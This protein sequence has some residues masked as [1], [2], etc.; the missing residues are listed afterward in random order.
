MA[1]ATLCG[2]LG[3]SFV[4]TQK[5]FPSLLLNV[6]RT[7]MALHSSAFLHNQATGK[8]SVN[9]AG[10][11]VFYDQRGSGSHPILC[12]PGALGTADGDF[13]PQLEYF[14]KEGGPYTIVGYDPMGYGASRP[15]ERNFSMKSE[16]FFER[17]ASDGHSL[18]Q[19]LSFPKFSLLG[20][21]DGGIAA[22]ILAARFPQAV[23]KL[24][25]WGANSY[26]TDKDI[27]LFENTRNVTSWSD[28]MRKPMEVMYGKTN[29]QNLWGDWVDSMRDIQK[30]TSDGDLCKKGLSKIQ[31][32]TLIV[33]GAKD[34][35]VPSFHP[36]YINDH[37][38]DSRLVVMPDGK[39]NLHWKYA[40][41]FNKLVDN[42]LS[43]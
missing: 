3:R 30:A 15:P 27:A 21:S 6:S 40:K 32:P 33:H 4:Y 25:I 12:I 17:D 42:F 1:T 31:C 23:Q 43:E 14:G 28:R 38:P 19:K 20:W 16:I 39:H 8:K 22:L 36:E 5:C 24:V 10:E 18:M 29:F 13:L 11:E 41:E 9:A 34:A 2:C 26:I 7:K 35:M 37:V